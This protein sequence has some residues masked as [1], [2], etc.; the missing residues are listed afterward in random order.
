MKA[1]TVPLT[2]FILLSFTLRAHAQIL[3]AV[4][5]EGNTLFNG[6]MKPRSKPSQEAYTEEELLEA[7]TNAER[8]SKLF[9]LAQD[10]ALYYPAPKAGEISTIHLNQNMNARRIP[11]ILGEEARARNRAENKKKLN[12]LTLVHVV[13]HEV[14]VQGDIYPGYA[15]VKGIYIKSIKC[16]A[17]P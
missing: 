11:R 8:G 6:A 3:K 9:L 5:I 17:V 2:V 10:G 12:W 15:G 1:I 7:K 16:D 13:G 14:E 4:V